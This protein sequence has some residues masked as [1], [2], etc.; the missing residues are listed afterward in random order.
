ML[1]FTLDTLRLTIHVIAA[2][3]W[4]GGQVVL[5]A[6]VPTLRSIGPHAPGLA[7][8]RFAMVAWPAFAVLVATGIWNI[9]DTDFDNVGDGYH[10]TL[11]IKLLLVTLSG[12]SAAAHAA[13][14]RTAIIAAGGAVGL[15]ASLAAV[16]V[17]VQL[18][19]S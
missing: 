13:S 4:V 3:V 19:G 15:I 16:I 5:G 7:A 1:P 6:L 10:L 18:S 12:M 11:G 9:L 2:C 17:G 14:D 8:R